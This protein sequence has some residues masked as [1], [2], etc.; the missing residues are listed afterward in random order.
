MLSSL[1]SPSRI[2]VLLALAGLASACAKPV[3]PLPGQINEV[4]LEIP[5]GE[6][7]IV[8]WRIAN[9][10]AASDGYTF[11][12]RPI[13]SNKPTAEELQAQED[14]DEKNAVYRDYLT[15]KDMLLRVQDLVAPGFQDDLLRAARGNFRH[16]GTGSEPVKIN[17]SGGKPLKLIVRPKSVVLAPQTEEQR[18]TGASAGR[19]AIAILA[20][21]RA[22]ESRLSASGTYRLVDAETGE[23]LRSGSFRALWQ[24]SRHAQFSS[25]GRDF[26][27]REIMVQIAR[28][29]GG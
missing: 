19:F 27:A 23:A 13:S 18:T 22:V 15:S 4:T 9:R 11:T 5:D 6:V 7:A 29:G 8:D 12:R 24:A 21:A 14:V 3:P 16:L 1:L 25:N 2:V 17:T 26:L 10:E 28:A 20:G